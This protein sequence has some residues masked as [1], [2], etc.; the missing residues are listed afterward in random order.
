MII[1]QT[2]ITKFLKLK[3]DKNNFVFNKYYNSRVLIHLLLFL[4]LKRGNGLQ[5]DLVELL[6]SI[7]QI[8]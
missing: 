7:K 8:T 6:I 2:T 4:D 1:Y 3:I 5:S